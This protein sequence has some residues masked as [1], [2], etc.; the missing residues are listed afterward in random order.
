MSEE[1]RYIIAL[2]HGTFARNSLWANPK[3]P[4]GEALVDRLGSVKFITK[5]WTG[6]NRQ[7]SRIAAAEAL[8]SELSLACDEHANAKTFIIAHSHGGNVA[9]YALRDQK[10]QS[11]VTGV[12]CINTPFVA[13]MRRNTGFVALALIIGFILLFSSVL[14]AYPFFPTVDVT[15][16]LRSDAS[17]TTKALL[18]FFGDG[19]G[20]VMV[21]LMLLAAVAVPAFMLWKHRADYDAMFQENREEAVARI[22][23]PTITKPKVFCVWSAGD[24]VVGAFSVLEGLGNLTYILLHPVLFLAAIAFFL[25]KEY[26]DGGLGCHMTDLLLPWLA[27]APLRWPAPN[28]LQSVPKIVCGWGYWIFGYAFFLA[29]L[30]MFLNIVLRLFPV[31]IN[32]REFIDTFF[33]KLFFTPTP[34]TAQRVEFLDVALPPQW[35]AHSAGHGSEIT[36][37][38]IVEWIERQSD[39]P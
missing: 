12:V 29:F 7:S 38:R 1:S 39:M 19:Y 11:K 4:L 15:L 22:E 33:V 13:A 10:L 5:K 9:L 37:K 25:V 6:Y 26:W 8:R 32:V 14:L 17:H 30:T 2:V 31:G 16:P 24:E 35:L 36:I 21:Q 23:L 27:D 18:W 34:V 3:S 28:P 20:P